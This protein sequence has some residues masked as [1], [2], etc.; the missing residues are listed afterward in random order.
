MSAAPSPPLHPPLASAVPSAAR[1]CALCRGMRSACGIFARRNGCQCG[2]VPRMLSQRG[3]RLREHR[4]GRRPSDASTAATQNAI[5]VYCGPAGPALTVL[6]GG[7]SARDRPHR[8]S[9]IESRPRNVI[10]QA[11]LCERAL[12]ALPAP[13]LSAASHQK[14][15]VPICPRDP[16]RPHF[17][18]ARSPP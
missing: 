17:P 18:A 10:H 11:K 14:R 6:S 5:S 1:R 7:R 16:R 15:H 8:C 9:E 3:G 12:E 2:E 13:A 4:R